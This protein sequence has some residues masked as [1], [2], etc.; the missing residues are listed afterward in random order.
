MH[1]RM[2]RLNTSLNEERVILLTATELPQSAFRRQSTAG[3]VISEDCIA[4]SFPSSQKCAKQ[5]QRPRPY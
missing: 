3:K 2:Y 4:I 1:S 5:V